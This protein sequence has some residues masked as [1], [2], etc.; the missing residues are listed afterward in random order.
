MCRERPAVAWV[1]GGSVGVLLCEP[2]VAYL[3][4]LADF[5]SLGGEVARPNCG[6]FSAG[7]FWVREGIGEGDFVGG[8]VAR[9]G[10][11]FVLGC[12]TGAGGGEATGSGWSTAG[13]FWVGGEGVG[14]AGGG[15]GGFDAIILGRALIGN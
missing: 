3:L 2:V 9:A 7:F 11:G 14:F 13:F 8:E 4:L 15:M 1:N 10:V 12:R 5:F 6:R